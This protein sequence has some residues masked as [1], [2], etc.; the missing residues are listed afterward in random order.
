MRVCAYLFV[1][2]SL[3]LVQVSCAGCAVVSFNML[4]REYVQNFSPF[5]LQA[6][7]R[8]KEGRYEMWEKISEGTFSFVWI[9]KDLKHKRFVAVKIP[10]RDEAN[11]NASL[12]QEIQVLSRIG[13]NDE[14]DQYNCV[15]LLDQFSIRTRTST[16]QISVMELL[17]ISLRE[18]LQQRPVRICTKAGG[19]K[20][21]LVQAAAQRT[22]KALSYLHDDL[23]I[24][25][26]DLK[27]ENI[28]LKQPWVKMGWEPTFEDFDVKLIDFGNFSQ[29]GWFQ[30]NYIPQTPNYR[31]PEAILGY[32]EAPEMDMWSLGCVMFELLT[33]ETLFDVQE[34]KQLVANLDHLHQMQQLLGPCPKK[35]SIG[36]HH[37]R[38]YFTP[39]GQLHGTIK[40]H[41]SMTGLLRHL[42]TV[43]YAFL[44]KN[45]QELL[46]FFD[47][48]S[49]C[50]C[51][52]PA[53][54]ITAEEAL[55]HPWL[56]GDYSITYRFINE[57]RRQSS[58]KLSRRQSTLRRQ[59][60]IRRQRSR[61]P[62]RRMSKSS[63]TSN[64]SPPFTSTLSGMFGCFFQ[65]KGGEETLRTNSGRKL[66]YIN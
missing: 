7:T 43:K 60:T 1:L 56:T 22:L 58:R 18:I 9:A 36:G 5:K 51:Y 44:F 30:P 42:I 46:A 32:P 21:P 41:N 10:K 6:F 59:S 57:G 15:R 66:S 19:L 65:W 55:E 26:N 8:L 11:L 50:L 45:H 61:S 53:K 64:N 24:V 38:L 35:V 13:M 25:H 63:V 34:C 16:F 2:L 29:A 37:S 49:G 33:G 28:A 27:P 47:F 4:G 20:M 48:L 52:D 3:L 12:R 17:G 54:R 31:S 23:G 14:E 40:D 62:K 39:N